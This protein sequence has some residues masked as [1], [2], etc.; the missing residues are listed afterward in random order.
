MT[1]TVPD[2]IVLLSSIGVERAD[3]FPFKILN[4]F[5]ILDAKRKSELLVLEACKKLGSTA[6]IIRP[7]R[8]VGA[9]FTNFDLAKL[10]QKTQES[11]MGIILD[12]RDNLAGDVERKDVASLVLRMIESNLSRKSHILS[13]INKAGASPS[14]VEWAQLLSLFTVP[15]E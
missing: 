12:V 9:P 15:D 2:K 7:G 8:L 11:N 1:K 10:L 3:Q 14:E 5:G 6:V 4:S 13:V